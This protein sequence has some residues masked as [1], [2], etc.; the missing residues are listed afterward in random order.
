M[1]QSQTQCPSSRITPMSLYAIS[2]HGEVTNTS[3][4]YLSAESLY[5]L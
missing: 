3:T 2:L 1:S 4:V 5:S